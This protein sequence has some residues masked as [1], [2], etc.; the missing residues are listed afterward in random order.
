MDQN[1]SGSLSDE[2][3]AIVPCKREEN[4]SDYF[5]SAEAPSASRSSDGNN[6]ARKR[7]RKVKSRP[8]SRRMTSDSEIEEEI[9]LFRIL[10]GFFFKKVDQP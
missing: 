3:P 10:E 5:E 9:G 2:D 6:R 4:D 1:K 7:A 8:R